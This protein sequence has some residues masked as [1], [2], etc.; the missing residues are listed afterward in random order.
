MPDL[1]EAAMRLEGAV[2]KYLDEDP[3]LEAV[4]RRMEP[5]L[6][7]I[8]DGDVPPQRVFESIA[9]RHSEAFEKHDDLEE[10]FEALDEAYDAAHLK[11]IRDS[12]GSRFVEH[13][14]EKWTRR[15]C[16]AC[17]SRVWTVPKCL[18]ELR[19]YSGGALVIGGDM[20]LFAVVPVVCESC[21]Y[22]HFFSATRAGLQKADADW[23]RL[24]ARR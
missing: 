4:M 5:L 17:G 16:P 7:R 24:P 20:N 13:L 8:Y 23:P 19:E 22:T 6:K 11:Q 9:S 2:K 3:E 15:D 10:A 18:F 12:V 1:V 21:G 14:D